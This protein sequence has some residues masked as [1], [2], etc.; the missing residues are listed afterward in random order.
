MSAWGMGLIRFKRICLIVL[1]AP[2]LNNVNA[3]NIYTYESFD[4]SILM[5]NIKQKTSNFKKVDVVFLPDS[6]MHSYQ[7]WGGNNP[8][9]V[10]RFSKNIS[11]SK[12]IK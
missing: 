12:L 9:I 2:F 3:Q 11:L 8:S 1:I 5:T 10:K 6:N 7:N 4:G